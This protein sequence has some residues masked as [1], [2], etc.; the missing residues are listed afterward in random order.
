MSWVPP[1]S[2]TLIHPIWKFGEDWGTDSSEPKFQL[3]DFFVVTLVL[4][5]PYCPYCPQ[6][7][8]CCF[9]HLINVAAPVIRTAAPAA[10]PQAAHS[11]QL[12]EAGQLTNDS[13]KF[14]VDS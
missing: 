7:V 4:Y 2:K 11:G 5:C 6:T 9:I 10:D 8:G 13:S 14:K 3:R 12:T 1:K